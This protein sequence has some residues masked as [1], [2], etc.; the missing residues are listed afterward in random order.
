MSKLLQ[1]ACTCVRGHDDNG[2]TEIYKTTVSISQSAFVEH[3]KKHVEHVAVGLLNFI[4]KNDAVRLTANL[5]RELT[6]FLISYIS[7]RRSYKTRGIETLGIFAHVNTYEGIGRTEHVLCK[8]LCEIC[9]THTR[10]TKEHKHTDRV[11]R[12]TK[13]NSVTLY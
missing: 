12:I 4:Q 9:L 1:L 6:A 11:V 13:S 8:F 5:L 10:R 2:V 7:R 3:L